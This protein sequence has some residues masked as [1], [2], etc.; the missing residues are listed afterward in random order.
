LQPAGAVGGGAAGR[1]DGEGW[2]VGRG[3]GGGVV[4]GGG[5]RGGLAGDC[6]VRD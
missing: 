3:G 6:A 4:D 2:R 1:D 5:G